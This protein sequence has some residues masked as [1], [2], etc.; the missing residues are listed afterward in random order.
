MLVNP[1][2]NYSTAFNGINNAVKKREQA[3]NEFRKIMAKHAKA[4]ETIKTANNMV[5]ISEIKRQA[6]QCRDNF[7]HLNDQ[8][9][10]ETS[11]FYNKRID[12]I[13]PCLQALGVTQ[14]DHYGQQMTYY[15][16]VL[17]VEYTTEKVDYL[18]TTN[19]AIKKLKS[20]SIVNST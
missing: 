19:D 9:I 7:L 18:N 17:P 4:T 16:K 15:N 2:K 13:S 11:L 10:R 6:E 8:L 1:L 12:Y 3:L 20:L 14:I 5:K